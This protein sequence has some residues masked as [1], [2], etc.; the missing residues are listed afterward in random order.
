MLAH[1]S[2]SHGFEYLAWDLGTV[3]AQKL[4]KSSNNEVYAFKRV[5]TMQFVPRDDYIQ[6]C[7]EAEAV[8]RHLDRSR[9]RKPVYII[10][11]VKTVYGAKAKSYKSRGHV[12]KLGGSIDGTVWSGGASPVSVDPGVEGKRETKSSTTWEGS[13]DFVFAF[14]V[15]KVHVNKKT[16]VPDEKHDYKKGALL[17]SEIDKNR[18]DLPDLFISSQEDPKAEDEGYEEYKFTEGD[19]VVACAIFKTEDTDD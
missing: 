8:R 6:K 9:Y 10:T 5:V 3:S 12:S 14:R 7:I 4:I 2:F 1:L 18:E 15:R 13:S 16:Q 17:R 11:G 19:T